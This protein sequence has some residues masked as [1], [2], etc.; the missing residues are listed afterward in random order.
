MRITHY[1]ILEL[2]NIANQQEIK[3]SYKRLAL[4]WH[5]DRAKDWATGDQLDDCEKV[6]KR[7]S[8]AYETLKDPIK[9]QEYNLVQHLPLSVEE[10]KQEQLFSQQWNSLKKSYD[11]YHARMQ[12]PEAYMAYL[13]S[14]IAQA[15][16]Q[17]KELISKLQKIG[18]EAESFPIVFGQYQRQAESKISELEKKNQTLEQELSLQIKQ[19]LQVAQQNTTLMIEIEKLRQQNREL[20]LRQT[21]YNANA[22]LPSN[23]TLTPQETDNSLNSKTKGANLGIFFS[24][25]KN[26]HPTIPM[27]AVNN[28]SK[29]IPRGLTAIYKILDANFKNKLEYCGIKLVF[30]NENV[31]RH[32]KKELLNYFK[33]QKIHSFTLL[34][35]E[36]F[37]APIQA[38][39]IYKLQFMNC[40]AYFASAQH[41]ERSGEYLLAELEKYVDISNVPQ[42]FRL[43]Y[44]NSEV[45]EAEIPEEFISK[46]MIF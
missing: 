2:Q 20:N 3:E 29:V 34:I 22:N 16:D 31:A 15:Q 43:A 27:T 35:D 1:Q 12:D 44:Q 40:D 8:M 33:K 19:N 25:E 11:V 45:N 46:K 36:M 13:Q 37:H 42:S 26:S 7:I 14:Q 23:S 30:E 18:K 9:R 28:A 32:F 10:N 39:Y 4:I 21:R 6:F 41:P 17:S 38:V 5:P 24:Q